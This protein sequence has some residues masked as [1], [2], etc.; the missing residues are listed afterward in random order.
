MWSPFEPRCLPTWV[1]SEGRERLRAHQDHGRAHRSSGEDQDLAVDLLERSRRRLAR[2]IDARATN[3]VA[4]G[5]RVRRRNRVDLMQRPHLH[6]TP[7]SGAQVV[8]QDRVLGAEDAAGV[9]PLRVQAAA[10]VD[11]HRYALACVAR[12]VQGCRPQPTRL[13]DLVPARLADAQRR[14]GA[15][16]EVVQRPPAEPPR[17]HAPGRPVGRVV[18]GALEDLA[19]R[20][21]R[22]GQVEVRAAA[23]EVADH[24]LCPLALD[25]PV[26]VGEVADVHRLAEVVGAEVATALEHR[27]PGRVLAR[28]LVELGKPPGG[29]RAAESGPDDADVDTLGHQ[30]SEPPFVRSR[31]SRR[32]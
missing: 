17:P 6:A 19:R 2:R 7:D 8:G 22:G 30:G 24:D 9:A 32:R 10:E 14:L 13:R 25:Q 5:P 20:P 29:D 23:D 1:E 16:I 11:R 31:A 15:G 3:D 4:V 27:D 18:V 26:D 12:V 28:G 21:Q